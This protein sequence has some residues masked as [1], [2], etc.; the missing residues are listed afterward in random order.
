MEVVV[1]FFFQLKRCWAMGKPQDTFLGVG[2]HKIARAGLRDPE[3][4]NFGCCPYVTGSQALGH[5]GAAG[6]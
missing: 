3:P 6:S 4:N 2:E 1:A 5:P